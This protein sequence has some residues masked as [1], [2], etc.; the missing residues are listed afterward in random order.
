MFLFLWILTF[1]QLN[2]DLTFFENTVDP[3]QLASDEA[4]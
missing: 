3:D 1:D 2:L 4:I